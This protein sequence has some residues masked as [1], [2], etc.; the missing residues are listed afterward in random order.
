MKRKGPLITLLAGLVLA[1]TLI[2][3]NMNATKSPPTYGLPDAQAVAPTA[4]APTAPA[5]TAPAERVTFAGSTVGGA[6]SIAIAVKD[7]HAV[8]YLCDGRAEA[9]LQGT[10]S[11][12]ALALS[13]TGNASLTG[14]YG[15]G[16]AA[17]SITAAGH[18]W[19]FSVKEVKPPSG[20]YRSTATVRNA[21][22]VGGWI[23][24]ANGKQVGVL[25][26]AGVP[27][28]APE[29]AVAPDG[30]GGTVTVDGTTITAV[31]VDGSAL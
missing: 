15:N 5:T 2:V 11:G 10:A 19:S 31:D 22:V 30:S 29:L 21:T 24:L 25:N 20:L 27:E 17:G 3:V 6:A 12:G 1:L 9:W 23:V 7:G 18:T 8:A 4:A 13:G 14:S 28:P 26:V 16:A